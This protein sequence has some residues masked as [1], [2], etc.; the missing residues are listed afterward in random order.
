MGDT[1][2]LVPWSRGAAASVDETE[3]GRCREG[4]GR[5]R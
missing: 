2:P 1:L 3:A 4:E 5:L